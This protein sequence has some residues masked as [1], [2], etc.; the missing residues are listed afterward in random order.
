MLTTATQ[1]EE[2]RPITGECPQ[3]E[4]ALAGAGA[5]LCRLPAGG[6]ATVWPRGV[7]CEPHP[8]P[9][10]AGLHACGT[11]EPG[12]WE[13]GRGLGFYHLRTLCPSPA[14]P[15]PGGLGFKE[16]LI[17]APLGSVWGNEIDP[18]VGRSLQS[19]LQAR[20]LSSPQDPL[21]L[22]SAHPLLG[23]WCANHTVLMGFP[24]PKRHGSE[25]CPWAEEAH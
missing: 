3:R 20:V 7:L 17:S 16:H 13:A 21:G 19:G 14:L 9:A 15:I 24:H 11:K 18:A 10:W 6:L 2:T 5:R 23:G 1:K 25:G 12:A 22:L 4:A 8:L